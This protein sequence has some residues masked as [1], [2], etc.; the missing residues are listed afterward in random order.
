MCVG[1]GEFDESD[2]NKLCYTA[3]FEEYSR[4]IEAHIENTVSED[5]KVKSRER[6]R[7]LVAICS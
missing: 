3:I 4:T 7:G 5:I 6:G 1:E 2:E